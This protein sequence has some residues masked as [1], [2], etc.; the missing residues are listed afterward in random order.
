M[1]RTSVARFSILFFIIVVIELICDF[2]DSLKSIHYFAKPAIVISLLFYFI[3]HSQHISVGLKKLTVLG[4][5]FSVLGDILLMFVDISSNYFMLGLVAFLFAH[6][7]YILV[8]LKHRNN[9]MQPIWF[10]FILIVYASGLIYLL[11]D[12]LGELLIPVVVYIAVIL[13]MG[14]TAFLRKGN[15]SRGSYNWVIMGAI[16]FIVS[17]SILALNK[18]YQEFWHSS[19]SIMITYALAQYFIAIGVLKLKSDLR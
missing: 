2:N 17:D 5:L 4:L 19:I 12:G 11:K 1:P 14:T 6:V 7:M 10:V 16:L 15:V 3:K 13:T 9:A 8:F 18:F